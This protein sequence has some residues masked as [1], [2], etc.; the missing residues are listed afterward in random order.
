[1][2]RTATFQRLLRIWRL[3]EVSEAGDIRTAEAIER[4]HE[5][6]ARPISRREILGMAG[7][8]L[9]AA[10]PAGAA[11]RALSGAPRIAIV[12]GGL[13]GL[14]CADRL[15]ERGY[16]ATVYDSSSRLG[17]RCFSNRSLVPGM[18][19]ENGGELIDTSH[20]TMLRYAR[21]FRL[22]VESYIKKV[23]DEGY[24]FLGRRWSEDEVIDQFRAV[25]AGMQRDLHAISG[26][27]TFHSHNDADVSFDQMDLAS[28]F[29]ART[30][31]L[32]LI[33]ALLNEAY[34]AEYGL[35]TSNQSTLNFLGVMRLNKRSKFQPFG[36]SD[37]RYHLLDGND[38]IVQ[39]LANRIRGPILTGARLT[40][41][42]RAAS[43]RYLLNFNG[44][45]APETADA[46]VLAIPF[47]VLRQ[48]VLDP[49]LRF[50]ANK[51]RAISTLSYGTNAK[52]MVAFNGRPW[53]EMYGESGGV[54]SDLSNLQ[55]TWESNR[56]RSA[57][58]GIIT[59]YASGDRGASLRANGLQQQVGDFLIDFDVALP[60]TRARAVK[61]QGAYVAHLEHWPS[62]PQSL[63]SYTCYRPGQ[64]TTIAGLEGEPAGLVKFAGEHADSFYSSQGFMEGACLSGIRA[65]NDLLA[66]IKSGA[67]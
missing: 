18:A 16:A 37:E 8:A 47:T 4:H 51:L 32:P 48:V 45:S 39:G 1:M 53:A 52:T 23:G 7:I 13:A 42:A 41:L 5:E 20:K 10:S 67:L 29:A 2:P 59:D 25:V 15:D 14:A 27:A 34:L 40:K 44:S 55:A 57:A 61:R 9:A 66:D 49:S 43:G 60:G 35:E 62:N 28:Y 26:A 36:A 33:E 24:W 30:P 46:V 58:N 31:G 19:A 21:E 38:G 64:F 63:G 54:Y 3:A 22:P 11:A 6:H 56:G 17:G 12:G 65:A 50:S